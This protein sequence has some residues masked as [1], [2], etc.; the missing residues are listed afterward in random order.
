MTIKIPLSQA[1]SAEA[2]AAAV[3]TH[4]AKLVDHQMGKP[5]IAAP[6][7]DQLVED[8]IRRV[9]DT[10]GPVDQRKPDLFVADYEIIDDTPP[11]PPEPTLEEKRA[12]RF[13]ELGQKAMEAKNALLSAGRASLLT[14]EAQEAGA[15]PEDE[16]SPEQ[17]AIV[18]RYIEYSRQMQAI[19]RRVAEIAVEIE[20]LTADTVDAYQVKF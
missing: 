4:I 6:R 3:E 10:E 9:V 11:P 5:G 13:A 20:D 2:F 12:K 16:R 18:D 14:M 8:A 7:A 19:T 1:G 15:I 17:Q